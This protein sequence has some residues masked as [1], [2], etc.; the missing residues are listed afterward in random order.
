MGT[1]TTPPSTDRDRKLWLFNCADTFSGNPKWLFLY[2][3]RNRPDIDAW[4]IT[5]DEDTVREVKRLGYQAATF[6]S[7]HGHGLQQRA[8]VWVVNQVKELIPPLMHGVLLLNLWHGVGVKS[9]ERGMNEGYLRERI[10]RKYIRNTE[11]YQNH[12]LFL[13]TSPAMEEHFTRHIGLDEHQ[14]V[15]GGYPQNLY[16]GQFGE[17]ATYDH[18]LLGSRGLPSDTRI[19]LYAPTPRREFTT[20]FLDSALPDPAALVETLEREGILLIIKMHPHMSE[21]PAF[22]RWREAH[23]QSRHLLFWDNAHDVYEVFGRIDLAIVDYS[24]ILYDLLA[25]GVRH[26]IRYVFDYNDGQNAVLEPGTDYMQLSCGAVAEDFSSLLKLLGTSAEVPEPDLERIHDHFWS[27]STPDTFER[28]VEA[29]LAFTPGKG[30]LPTLYSFDIFDTLIARNVVEPRGVFY[31]VRDRIEDSHGLPGHFRSDYV[32]IRVQ[33]EANVREARRKREELVASGDLEITL[34]DIYDRLTDV[35]GLTPEQR[36]TLLELEL[37]GEYLSSIPRDNIIERALELARAGET[38]ILLS[39]MYL[40]EAFV[41]RLLAK[42]SPELAE[43]PLYLSNTWHA[44]KT[45]KRLFLEAYADLDYRFGEW[46]HVGDNQLADVTRPKTLGIETRPVKTPRLRPYERR[47]VSNIETYDSYLVAGML[48]RYSARY[49]PSQAEEFAYR[50]AALYLV[51]YIDWVIDD[52]V[53]RGYRTL[54][55]VSRDGHHMKPIADALIAARGLELRTRYIYGSR[56][57]WRL[58]AQFDGIDDA[59]FSAYGSFAGAQTI[60]ELAESADLTVDRLI[61]FVPGLRRYK[62][63]DLVPREQAEARDLMAAS[64]PL[65]THLRERS[66]EARDLACDYFRQEMD[67]DEPFGV[68]EYWGRG[69]TQDCMVRLIASATGAPRPVPFY[70]ARSIYLTDGEA[71]RH[72]FTTSTYSMLVIEALFANLP[73]GTVE[74]YERQPDGTVAPITSPRD[75]DQELHAAMELRLPEFARDFA[76]LPLRDRARTRRDLFAF[77]FL[78]YNENQELPLYLDRIAHLQDAVSLGASEQEF[79]PRLTLRDFF[80][81]MGGLQLKSISRSVPMSQARTRPAIRALFEAKRR[82]NWPRWVPEERRTPD[83]P[84]RWRRDRKQPAAKRR[85]TK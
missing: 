29:A 15:R 14:I 13:V 56:R 78:D 73:Y 82:H 18:D 10:A 34:D 53:A 64:A 68:V 63:T 75:F 2:V 31:Y 60:E 43:L 17:V 22:L 83:H 44:Q 76:E 3:V 24:S 37:E 69:Y 20:D 36:A 21:D 77:A 71:V 42:A 47:L 66:H 58:A 38:V 12:Q 49:R 28:L 5:K 19:A 40:P 79:A 7:R 25:A 11:Y 65:R 33:A 57:A 39:D 46:Q 23:G 74:R 55:F 4:W 45:T 54:Y 84:E 1:S 72:N 81:Y 61:G 30:K 6:D 59:T 62:D 50:C 35:Y 70:Y 80:R 32:P 26:V 48:Q 85:K 41:K 8:G 9:I 67:L 16:T 52:A 51:P 27:Y